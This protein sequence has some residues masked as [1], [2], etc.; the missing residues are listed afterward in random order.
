M[1]SN[2]TVPKNINQKVPNTKKVMKQVPAIVRTPVK[3]L[4]NQNGG[5]AI[6]QG[7]NIIKIIR[8]KMFMENPQNRQLQHINSTNN[9]IRNQQYV[10]KPPVQ[11]VP[12][13]KM[14]VNQPV[15]QQHTEKK[16]IRRIINRPTQQGVAQNLFNRLSPQK[17]QNVNNIRTNG[18][19]VYGQN[20]VF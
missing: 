13:Q 3:G 6:S 20:N 5:G 4:N 15:N 10:N 11:N 2:V 12:Q 9:L 7:K 16:I 14:L 17:P 8:P 19:F 18:H 1:Y